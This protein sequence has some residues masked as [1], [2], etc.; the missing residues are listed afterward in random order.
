M[1]NKI[2]CVAAKIAHVLVIV[3]ALN[4]GLYGIGMFMGSNF[5]LVNLIFGTM[6]TIEAIVYVLVGISAVV[7][8]FGCPC[9]N[10]KSCQVEAAPATPA[11]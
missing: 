7:G 2:G 1:N 11:Q 10:C 8:I 9:T 4:W 3:G 6:P 5:N